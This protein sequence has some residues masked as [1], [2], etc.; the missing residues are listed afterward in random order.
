[1]NMLIGICYFI[2]LCTFCWTIWRW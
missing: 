2:V 1:M